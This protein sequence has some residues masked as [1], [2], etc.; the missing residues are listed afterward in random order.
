MPII[1]RSNVDSF[2]GILRSNPPRT[3]EEYK[4]IVS[5]LD[6]WVDKD[7]KL[8]TENAKM[9]KPVQGERWLVRGL[10]FLASNGLYR[11]A[12]DTPGAWGLDDVDLAK[13]K[14]LNMCPGASEGCKSM[15]LV[16]AGQMGLKTSRQAQVNRSMAWVVNKQS[17]RLAMIVAITKL[18]SKSRKQNR[19]LGFRLNVT[20]DLPWERI[21]IE[22]PEWLANYMRGYGLR[23]VKAGRYPNIMK[24]FDGPYDR[25]QVMFYDYT[26]IRNRILDTRSADW[27]RNYW[28]TWS[29]DERAE[30]RQTALEVLEKQISTVAVPFNRISGRQRKD[31]SWTIP[32]D[33]LPET[34]SFTDHGQVVATFPIVDAD[35][36]DLRFK[37]AARSISGLRFKIP[38]KAEL[39]GTKNKDKAGLSSGFIVNAPTQ[40]P[41]VSLQGAEYDNVGTNPRRRSWRY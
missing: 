10:A 11:L 28:L 7:N 40:H 21:P 25:P 15:C 3:P 17:V 24:I 18:W 14:N 32:K 4:H 31:G 8:I 39:K 6:G 27:P 38:K 1:F 2:A 41:S 22:V 30:S 9:N 5:S 37:D 33:P 16:D 36:H 19:R 29:M 34:L 13:L 12:K 20:S 26:K 23:W 35:K